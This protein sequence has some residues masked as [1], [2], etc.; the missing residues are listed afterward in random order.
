M[1]LVLVNAP[2]LTIITPSPAATNAY[3]SFII[4]ADT[5]ASIV[6]TPTTDPN[7]LIDNMNVCT[8]LSISISG[9]VGNN[10]YSD[11]IL[12]NG[13]SIYSTEN[14]QPLI[15]QG[16]S[17]TGPMGSTVTVTACGQTSVMVD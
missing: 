7:M 1:K 12:L 8:K 11:T 5:V 16:Q 9:K 10:P 17:Q 2:D 14:N 4:P 15:L 3:L 6:I 13:G